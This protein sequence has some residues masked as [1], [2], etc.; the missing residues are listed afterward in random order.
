MT[1]SPD[2]RGFR[3]GILATFGVVLILGIVVVVLVRNTRSRTSNA[4]QPPR[5]CVQSSRIIHVSGVIGSEKGPFFKDERVRARF[6]CAGLD[7]T[8]DPSGSRDMPKVL[9]SPNHHYDF[10]FPSSTPTAEKIMRDRKIIDKFTPFS[11]PMAVATFRPP[12]EAL[13]RAGVVRPGPVGPP[14]LDI[15]ALLDLERQGT[16]W[17]QLPGNIPYRRV[18]LVNTTDP[19]DS[20]SGI[21]YLAIVSYV[22]ND[23]AVVT[24]A[25]QVQRVLPVLCRVIFDQ[26]AKP[27]TSQVL[28][29]SY[30]VDSLG[31]IGRIPMALIYEAQFTARVPGQK[32]LLTPD[33]VLLYPNPTVYSRH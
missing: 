3:R 21:M 26:G 14:V 16:R 18:V 29:D 15:A 17:Y 32:P 5:P 13:A 8:V 20:N 22:A 25:E 4:D 1:A 30:L 28:F 19:Q 2:H 31:G 7:V 12:E 10:A 23:D 27:E 33:R 9:G 11:S 6:T 24:T